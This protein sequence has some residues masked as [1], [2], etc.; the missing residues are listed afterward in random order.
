MK[1]DSRVL[2]I[3]YSLLLVV[4]TA[5]AIGWMLN[6]YA[7]ADDLPYSHECI[8]GDN[9]TFWF[10][11]NAPVEHWSQ[12]GSS[13]VNHYNTCNGRLS[14]LM[15]FPLAMFPRTVS[16]V[17]CGLLIGVMF[18]L[19]LSLGR[20]SP[21]KIS[22]R[23]LAMAVTLLWLAIPW[24][25]NF[26]SI[27]F[28]LNYVLPSVMML[29]T[30]QLLREGSRWAW[31]TAVATGWCHEGFGTVLVAV[32]L[33]M[34]L[35]ARSGRRRIAVAVIM[36]VLGI[37]LSISPGTIL[38]IQEKAGT[39]PIAL[40]GIMTRFISQGWVVWLAGF[41]LIIYM[42][43]RRGR[44]RTLVVLKSVLPL[45]TGAVVGMAQAMVLKS[46]GR[47]LFPAIICAIAIV[48]VLVSEQAGESRPR[49]GAV[50]TASV[51]AIFYVLWLAAVIAVASHVCGQQ[52]EFDRVA[53][54]MCHSDRPVVCADLDIYDIPYWT[55][56]LTSNYYYLDYN[57][58]RAQSFRYDI[59]DGRLV[60][61]PA[62]LAGKTFDE[63]PL[64]PGTAGLYGIWPYVAG[65]TL[66]GEM[67]ESPR[68]RIYNTAFMVTL[69]EPTPS[70]TPLE[71]LALAI[72]RTLG[73]DGNSV[74]IGARGYP[75][76]IDGSERVS[77]DFDW[78]PRGYAN[79]EVL[80][81]DTIP[82]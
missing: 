57:Q 9:D 73:S 59:G 15:M 62:V 41:L 5:G 69:G 46:Y 81:I 18:W 61:M 27:A 53:R 31:L 20:L 14:N 22:L 77:Y 35:V 8:P 79:R 52:Q 10:C 28:Q 21:N 54:E 40:G 80:R 29:A 24:Y 58:N 68:G 63:W 19:L 78:M 16:E 49:R 72:R 2:R 37:G 6:T 43:M 36:T 13:I 47:V 33:A 51:A 74:E 38:R 30:I 7:Y 25:D 76:V 3:F 12:V 70:C 65:D 66:R 48:L 64:I 45:A 75:A 60:I 39:E 23:W 1:T 4:T 34:M 55:V 32:G 17:L 56:G 50:I 71:K 44:S 11:Q 82:R 26:Q 67:T 42:Y